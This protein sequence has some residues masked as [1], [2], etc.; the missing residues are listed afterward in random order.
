MKKEQIRVRVT[1]GDLREFKESILWKDIKRELISW[2][3]GFEM[4]L[5]SIVDN[6]ST[7]NP[8]TAAVLMHIGDINGRTKAVD[9]LL[10]IPDVFIAIIELEKDNSKSDDIDNEIGEVSD[11]N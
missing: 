3:H 8:S 2:K 4:E 10:S 9:Y 11:G 5:K 7:T 6:V 1:T